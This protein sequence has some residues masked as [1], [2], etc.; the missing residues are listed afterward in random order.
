VYLWYTHALRVYFLSFL[1]GGGDYVDNPYIH[2]PY[3]FLKM[4]LFVDII[5]LIET[6]IVEKA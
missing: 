3:C 5:D 4:P 6:Y 1:A 2:A